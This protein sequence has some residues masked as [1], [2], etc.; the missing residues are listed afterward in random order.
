VR[1]S[2]VDAAGKAYYRC[3]ETWYNQVTHEGWVCY[4]EVF[5]PAGLRVGSLPKGH[6]VIRAGDRTL[7][8]TG[9]AFYEAVLDGAGTRYVVVEPAVGTVLNGYRTE[10]ERGSRCGRAVTTTTAISASSIARRP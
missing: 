6:E 5:P 9:D 1:T 8:A 4:S 10:R 2:K 7:Y 3:G